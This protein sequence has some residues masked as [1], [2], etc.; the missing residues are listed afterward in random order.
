MLIQIH[1][2]QGDPIQS[3][4]HLFKEILAAC[5][6]VERNFNCVTFCSQVL[7]QCVSLKIQHHLVKTS[8]GRQVEDPRLN[9]SRG[10][11]SDIISD[12][13]WCNIQEPNVSGQHVS[14]HNM[15][16]Q[17]VSEHKMCGHRTAKGEFAVS[18]CCPQLL[19]NPLIDRSRVRNNT[20]VI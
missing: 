2:N 18:V 4:S 10:G 3:L 13:G 1:Q 7:S 11:L 5:T 8:F 16:G 12:L 17:H 19:Q 6:A 15:C 9:L 20:F 14:V